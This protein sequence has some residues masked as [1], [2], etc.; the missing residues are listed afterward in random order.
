MNNAF[1]DLWDAYVHELEHIMHCDNEFVTAEI[2]SDMHARP[3]MWA[4]QF[5][6]YLK[7]GKQ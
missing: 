5:H 4:F 1:L 6:R 2:L 7:C 3:N